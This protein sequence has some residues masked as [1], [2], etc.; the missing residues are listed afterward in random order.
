[1]DSGAKVEL[2]GTGVRTTEVVA[3]V[4]ET[5]GGGEAPL[6]QSVL[7]AE[8]TVKAHGK[9]V[10]KVG[11]VLACSTSIYDVGVEADV[12]LKVCKMLVLFLEASNV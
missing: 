12:L 8:L 4:K 6:T 2:R 1:M 10:E 7:R 9:V 11:D 5:P 3:V